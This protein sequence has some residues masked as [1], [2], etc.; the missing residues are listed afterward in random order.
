MSQVANAAEEI[1]KLP[2][3]P[4]MVYKIR[5]VTNPSPQTSGTGYKGSRTNPL[6][7]N[8]SLGARLENKIRII[9]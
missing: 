8:S 3:Y 7:S 6:S 2:K 1:Q 4:P 5:L 9:L